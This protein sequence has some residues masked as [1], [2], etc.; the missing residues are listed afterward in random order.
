MTAANP[1]WG[2]TEDKIATQMKIYLRNAPD[3]RGGR[4][5]RKQQ[6]QQ[7]SLSK[8]RTS[9]HQCMSLCMSMWPFSKNKIVIVIT[10]QYLGS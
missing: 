8:T 10:E 1:V 6:Q 3:R 5:Q 4:N 2:A 7:P 9:D